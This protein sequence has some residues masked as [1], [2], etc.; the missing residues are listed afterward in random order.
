MTIPRSPAIDLIHPLVE[1][2]YRLPWIYE[3]K[4]MDLM[5]DKCFTP[6]KRTC[7][8]CKRILLADAPYQIKFCSVACRQLSKR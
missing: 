6:I 5:D 8:I 4:D 1:C 7:Q 2:G 3:D